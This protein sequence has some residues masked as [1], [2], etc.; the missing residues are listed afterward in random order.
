MLVKCSVPFCYVMLYFS[1]NR[2]Y[3]YPFT[4]TITKFREREKFREV[5]RNFV[6]ACLRF[7]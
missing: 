4:L 3:S 5:Q 1:I 6:V 7:P 2:N